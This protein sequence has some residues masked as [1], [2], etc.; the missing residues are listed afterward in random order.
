M[1]KTTLKSGLLALV[2]TATLMAPAV[3]ACEHSGAPHQHKAKHGQRMQHHAGMH[4]MLRGLALTD[5]QK[6][7]IK[8]LME[9]HQES[10]QAER[11]AH[12]EQM[13][14]YLTANK[15]DEK[16]MKKA[17]QE[18][19][20]KRDQA[21]IDMIKV[22]RDIYKLLTPEQQTK[23]KE[24]FVKQPQRGEHVRGGEHPQRGERKGDRP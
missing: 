6:A 15:F 14:A 21:A 20:V 4:Q 1:N 22:H 8:T 18:R 23:F 7:D 2:T 3:Y 12:K 9:K 16:K 24:N 5:Q 13:L 11:K 19:Q 10:R 17:M